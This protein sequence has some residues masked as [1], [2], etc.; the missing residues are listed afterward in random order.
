MLISAVFFTFSLLINLN[1]KENLRRTKYELQKNVEPKEEGDN[2][3]EN[4]N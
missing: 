3:N 4:G 1:N 2:I